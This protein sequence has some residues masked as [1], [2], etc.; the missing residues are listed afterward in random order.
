MM[1]HFFIRF[2][3]YGITFVNVEFVLNIL[4]T[5]FLLITSHCYFYNIFYID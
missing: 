2:G 5:T 1:L 3:F 4:K